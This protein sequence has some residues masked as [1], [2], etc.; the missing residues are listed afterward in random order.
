MDWVSIIPRALIGDIEVMVSVEETHTDTLQATEHPVET[1]SPITDHSYN[2]PCEVVLKC[3]W[4]NSSEFAASGAATK[5]LGNGG[6]SQ[7]DYVTAVY[8]QLLAL[9]ESREPFDVGTSRRA[10]KNMLITSMATTVD[11]K[12]SSVLMLT[13]TCREIIMVDT[14]A[15]TMPPK[16]NQA[17]PASTAATENSGTKQVSKKA[18]PA[19]GGA[20]SPFKGGSSAEGSFTAPANTG[21]A[22]GGW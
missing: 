6:M 11:Q 8:S 16:Q 3:G 17:N 12:T 15:T 1:G 19:P 13:C 22:T 9:K 4:S 14:Q 18:N 5:E 20:V 21:G 7:D 2:K 10:Y